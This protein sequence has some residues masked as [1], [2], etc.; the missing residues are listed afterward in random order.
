M[1]EKCLASSRK[2]EQKTAFCYSE[3]ALKLTLLTLNPTVP[4]I[5][6]V[7][8]DLLTVSLNLSLTLSLLIVNLTL[9]T[10]T[11]CLT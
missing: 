2:N 4:T 11:L 3:G 8:I 10:L 9:L 5:I 1:E 7:T 6:L